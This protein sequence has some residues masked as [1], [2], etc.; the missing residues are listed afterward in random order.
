MFNF[1]KIVN[2]LPEIG[3]GSFIPDGYILYKIGKE[4]IE[5]KDA[6]DK[7]IEANNLQLEISNAKNYLDSTDKYYARRN[8]TGEPVT[9]EVVS[10]RKTARDFLRANGVSDEK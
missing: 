7:E 1:Y 5:L 6:I 2:G 8:E 9:E 3:S 4:P 10:K